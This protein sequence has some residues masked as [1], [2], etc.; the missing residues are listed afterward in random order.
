MTN[1]R[2]Y[3]K[4]KEKENKKQ[5][6]FGK[7]ILRHRLT[8]LYR[9]VLIIAVI[10]AAAVVVVMQMKN[11]VFTGYETVLST[12]RENISGTMLTA[13][14]EN[15]L[16]YS[17]DGASCINKSGE[18]LWNQTFEMQSPILEK[19]GSTVAIGDYNGRSI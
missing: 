4:K 15:I 12:E 10:A 16:V 13:L 2:E 6:S 3:I 18:A 14:G 19:C 8:I 11:R 17:H 5:D 7:K 1:I 9:T